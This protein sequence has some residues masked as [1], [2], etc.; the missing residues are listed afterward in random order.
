MYE[1][2]VLLAFVRA[3]LRACMRACVLVCVCV[4]VRACL[5]TCVRACVRT[6][7]RACV[8]VCAILTKKPNK[9]HITYAI[10]HHMITSFAQIAKM[11]SYIRLKFHICRGGKLKLNGAQN[12]VFRGDIVCGWYKMFFI[13]I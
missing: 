13:N 5:L 11:L 7:L 12:T 8:R 1:L 6:C 4:Y 10:F 2:N 3:Y 9:W